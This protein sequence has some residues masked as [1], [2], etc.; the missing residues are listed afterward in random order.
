VDK[1]NGLL[2]GIYVQ[3]NKDDKVIL[4]AEHIAEEGHTFLILEDLTRMCLRQW[5]RQK[6]TH[7]GSFQ[8]PDKPDSF[9]FDH[10]TPA[11]KAAH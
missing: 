4:L 6:H 10:E 5:F 2:V 8:F 3:E 7:L 1:H 11:M 9:H